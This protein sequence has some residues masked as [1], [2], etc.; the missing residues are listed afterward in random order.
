VASLPE[1][2]RQLFDEHRLARAHGAEDVNGPDA[3]LV[4]VPAVLVR[5]PAVR[6]G[7]VRAHIYLDLVQSITLMNQNNDSLM[8]EIF[9]AAGTGPGMPRCCGYRYGIT[10]FV[11]FI[12]IVTGG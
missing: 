10:I 12:Y 11:D 5:L 2:G 7:H 6:L 1:D 3:V 9:V 4:E 8:A